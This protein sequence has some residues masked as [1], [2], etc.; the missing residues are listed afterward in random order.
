MGKASVCQEATHTQMHPYCLPTACQCHT[1]TENLHTQRGTCT[2]THSTQT[3]SHTHRH[4]LTH[5]ST[6]T[7]THTHTHS[8]STYMHTHTLTGLAHTHIHTQIHTST[9]KPLNVD[10]NMYSTSCKHVCICVVRIHNALPFF[11]SPASGST[12]QCPVPKQDNVCLG[13]VCTRPTPP[14]G[15]LTDPPYKVLIFV[16]P[17]THGIA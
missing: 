10:H 14:L 11:C 3:H 15:Q 16:L 1:H 4:T 13:S 8:S 12:S 2:H 6:P 7:H 17:K 5:T 9:D